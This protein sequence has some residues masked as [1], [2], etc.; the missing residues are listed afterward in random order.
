LLDSEKAE[1]TGTSG[2]LIQNFWFGTTGFVVA[3]FVFSEFSA[4]ALGVAPSELESCDLLLMMVLGC[5]PRMLADLVVDEIVLQ[6][7]LLASKSKESFTAVDDWPI[8]SSRS[9]WGS[10]MS[11]GGGCSS[12][13]SS[14]I[15]VWVIRFG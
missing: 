15:V 12:I 6:S 3:S 4:L 10:V 1:E 7:L 8:V 14:G 9:I 2:L 5:G 11:T 13:V